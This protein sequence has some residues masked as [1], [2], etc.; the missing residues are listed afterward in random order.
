MIS[1]T[2]EHDDWNRLLAAAKE[3]ATSW[4]EWPGEDLDR[5]SDAVET[6]I[7]DVSEQIDA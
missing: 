3:G 7:D 2:L 6:V 1:V 5:A 4:R